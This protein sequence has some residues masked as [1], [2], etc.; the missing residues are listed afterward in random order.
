MRVVSINGN[1]YPVAFTIKA[2]HDFAKGQGVELVS[3]AFSSLAFL[4]KFKKGYKVE[5]DDIDKVAGLTVAAIN[6]GLRKQ[7]KIVNVDFD[8][9][10]EGLINNAEA[11]TNVLAEVIDAMNAYL[12][13]SNEQGEKKK[14]LKQ[15][16]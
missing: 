11:V 16:A 12:E 4:S 2:L 3:E 10:Y 5:I 6:A 13:V 7:G 15:T 1:E 8:D 14:E 9:V